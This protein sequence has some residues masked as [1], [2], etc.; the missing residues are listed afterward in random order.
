ML[1]AGVLSCAAHAQEQRSEEHEDHLTWS[2]GR[3]PE[4]VVHDTLQRVGAFGFSTVTGRAYYL[5][6]NDGACASPMG[7]VASTESP[8]GGT[9]GSARVARWLSLDPAAAKYA[10]ISPYVGFGNNPII[11]VDPDGKEIWIQYKTKNERGK[12]VIRTARYE[13]GKLYD[14]GGDE[15]ESTRSALNFLQDVRQDLD[16][17]RNDDPELACRLEEME[18]SDFKHV[19]KFTSGKN[20]TRSRHKTWAMKGKPDDAIIGYNPRDEETMTGDNRTPRVGLAHE[21]FGHGWDI[22][23]GEMRS[24]KTPNGVPLREVDA[25]NI[26][27]LVRNATGEKIR[28]WFRSEKGPGGKMQRK[29]IPDEYLAPVKPPPGQEPPPIKGR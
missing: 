27:N 16:N 3:Y 23:K 26:E 5:G 7:G 2:A 12:T 21:L 22:E 20:T 18:Q 17:L 11:Y 10:H 25:I 8:V 1:V 29:L 24:G 15:L 9:V 28:N 14:R 4:V 6:S 13:N 19:I